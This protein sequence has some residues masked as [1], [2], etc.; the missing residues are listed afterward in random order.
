MRKKPSKVDCNNTDGLEVQVLF[1]SRPGGL[2]PPTHV[3]QQEHLWTP[4]QFQV[5]NVTFDLTHQHTSPA[6]TWGRLMTRL[7]VGNAS[8]R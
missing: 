3:Q 4:Q 2:A 5:E 7:N 6:E 8:I 1:C